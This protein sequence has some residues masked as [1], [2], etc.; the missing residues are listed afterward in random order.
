MNDG[1]EGA[2]APRRV[3]GF[4]P[5]RPPTATHN[6]LRV[7]DR[8]GGGRFV[9]KSGR[10]IEAEAKIEA[11]VAGIAPER[12]LAGPVA[13]TLRWCFETG[14]RHGQGEPHASKPDASNLLKTM[15]DCLVRCGVIED[16]RLVCAL[17][18]S[19]AWA[20]PPGIYVLAEEIGPRETPPAGL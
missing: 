12:P 16:D 9:G 20:D 15:E 6:D 18:V 4:L 3:E 13:L 17:S 8:R 5:M 19:K 10:L 11:A 7:R 1:Y 14:G 2:G